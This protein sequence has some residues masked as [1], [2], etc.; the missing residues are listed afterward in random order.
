LI[1]VARALISTLP[2]FGIGL[3]LVI[4]WLEEE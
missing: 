3:N 4:D 1:S 2:G